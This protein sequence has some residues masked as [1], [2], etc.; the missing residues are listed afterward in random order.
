MIC[1]FFLASRRSF[2]QESFTAL[3][4]PYPA[5]LF[6]KEE[7]LKQTPTIFFKGTMSKQVIAT[8][9]QHLE[10]DS[11]CIPQTQKVKQKCRKEV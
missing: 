2:K 6:L 4:D 9:R 3:W 1:S 11:P 10:I 5:A 8:I 7:N